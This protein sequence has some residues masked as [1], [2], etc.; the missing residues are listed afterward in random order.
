[1]LICE[2]LNGQADANLQQC[3]RNPINGNQTS[4][5]GI[6]LKYNG[7]YETA[8]GDFDVNF[9]TVIMDEWETEAFFNGP[10]VNYVGL[11]SVPEMRYSVDVGHAL[12]DYARVIPQYSV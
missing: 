6:D 9:S 12:R 10:V 2:R 8:V 7:L 11:T 5:S 1:M 4:T 3:F